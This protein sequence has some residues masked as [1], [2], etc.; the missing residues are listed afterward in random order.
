MGAAGNRC[1]DRFLPSVV[2]QAELPQRA[3]L[4]L[5]AGKREVR[6][7]V[8]GRRAVADDGQVSR[9]VLSRSALPTTDTELKLMAAAAIIGFSSRCAESGYNTPAAIGIPIAL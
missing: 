9:I 3:A 4:V 6:R 1:S 8:A 5:V 7:S 2:E